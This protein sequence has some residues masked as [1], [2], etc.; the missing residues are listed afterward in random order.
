[1]RLP[2]AFRRYTGGEVALEVAAATVGD[3]L[4]EAFRRHPDL[5]LRLVDDLG[6]VRSHLAV[7]H[8]EEQLRREEAA[9]VPL[10]AGDTLTL[11]VAVGGGRG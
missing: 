7:F 8:N 2:E 6:L 5:R 10:V 4:E 9:G 3:A 11:L 1:M